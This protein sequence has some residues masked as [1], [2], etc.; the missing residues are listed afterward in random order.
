MPDF[1]TIVPLPEYAFRISYHDQV[2]SMGSCFAEHIGNCLAER[3]F[4]SLLNPFGILYNPASIGQSLERL[5]QEA[6]FSAEEQF[7]HQGLWHTFWHHGIFSAPDKAQALERINRAFRQAQA[8]LLSANRLI[9]TLGTAFVFIYRASGEVAAN[10]HKMP[11]SAFERRRLSTKEVL[12]ALEPAL[13]E[14][15][16]RQP[17]LEIILTVSPVRHIRDGLIENQRSKAALLLAA[18]E[19]CQQHGFIHYFPAYEIMMDELRGYRFYAADMLHPSAEAVSYI[20]ERLSQVCFDEPTRQLI[21]KIEKIRTAS[22]HR[23]FHPQAPAHQQFLRQQLQQIE[24]LERESPFLNLEEERRR[25]EGQL[26][27]L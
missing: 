18:A 24:A 16:A 13:L 26:N 7:E 10:C 22:L 11:G 4:T 8:F 15:K 12:A 21:A 5:L 3:H 23:P 14:L 1:R 6:P 25:F 20:W 2:L 27:I 9:I 17:S 19:L